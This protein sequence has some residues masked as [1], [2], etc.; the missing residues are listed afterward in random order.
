M[1]GVGNPQNKLPVNGK[2]VTVGL[3]NAPE[4]DDILERELQ[5]VDGE[6]LRA[7]VYNGLVVSQSFKAFK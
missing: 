1:K 7:P 2:N 5:G 3:E 4:F 6:L